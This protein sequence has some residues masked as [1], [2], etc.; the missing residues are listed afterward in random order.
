MQ[1]G[2]DGRIERFGVFVGFADNHAAA[3]AAQ[4]FVGGGGDKVGKRHRAWV[5]ATGNQAGVVCHVDKQIS[6]YFVGD[7][8]ETRP[9]DFQCVGGSA[10]HNHF[11]LVFQRQAL[12]FGIVEHFVFIQAV[13]DDIVELAGNINGSAVGEMA[14]VGQTHAH[15]GVARFEHAGVHGLVGLR[16][17]MRLHVDIFTAKQLF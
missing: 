2:E 1:A 8:A 13:A 6:A 10:G 14:A 16:A 9:V 3:R 4:G 15:D 5:F 7:F 11:G 17:G 12:Y